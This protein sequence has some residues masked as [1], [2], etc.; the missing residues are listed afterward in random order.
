MIWT[1][2]FTLAVVG[3]LGFPLIQRV[4]EF[5]TKLLLLS[6]KG[7]VVIGSI[8]LIWLVGLRGFIALITLIIIT[9]VIFTVQL[10]VT[11]YRKITV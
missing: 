10:L 6:I 8:G 5:S 4:I 9:I 11:I 1:T 3:Y 2:I 7:L